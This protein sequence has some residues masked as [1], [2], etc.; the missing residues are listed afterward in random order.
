MLI[1][2]YTTPL[3]TLVFNFDVL[4]V[5]YSVFHNVEIKISGFVFV[6]DCCLATTFIHYS[7]IES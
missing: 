2:V 3:V 7:V 4:C 1:S 5:R 6:F